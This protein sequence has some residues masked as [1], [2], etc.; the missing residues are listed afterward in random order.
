MTRTTL[1]L[2]FALFAATS[3][4][5]DDAELGSERLEG[6]VFGG[7]GGGEECPKLGCGSNSAYL[8]PTDFHDLH[9]T[10]L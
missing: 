8:G 3:A 1:L 4:C 9:E 5:V 6:I 10:G 2:P 7:G